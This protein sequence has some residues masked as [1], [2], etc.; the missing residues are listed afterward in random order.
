MRLDKWLWAARFF[1]TRGMARAAIE[2]GRVRMGGERVKPAKE[3]SP[4]SRI[5]VGTGATTCEIV[6]VRLGERRGP[7]HEAQLLYEETPESRERRAQVA[8]RVR[9]APEPTRH[10]RGRPTKRDRRQLTR[11][12]GEE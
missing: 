12:R 6:V 10:L 7:A 2:G 3:I 4:G 1:K 9:L 11:F 5:E 8:E